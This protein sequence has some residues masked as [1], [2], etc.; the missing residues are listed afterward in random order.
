MEEEKDGDQGEFLPIAARTPTVIDEREIESLGRIASSKQMEPVS[1]FYRKAWPFLTSPSVAPARH[2]AFKR[3][4]SP[5]SRS[6]SASRPK[7]SCAAYRLHGGSFT[8][9][10]A[11]WR[12]ESSFSSLDA[13]AAGAALSSK[14]SVDIW[15]VL[16]WNLAAQSTSKG[17]IL[18]R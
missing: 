10:M 3:P 11:C 17:L 9:S 18:T 13:R 2:Y 16:P 15:A 12:V 6:H 8:A 4:S 1:R 7:H 5:A 14:L